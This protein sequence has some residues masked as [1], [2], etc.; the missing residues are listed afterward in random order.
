[1]ATVATINQCLTQLKSLMDTALV[2]TY[3]KKVYDYR[4][5]PNKLT[6]EVALSYQGQ[7]D[8]GSTLGGQYG[9]YD[10][11]AVIGA[12]V[13]ESNTDPE[14]ALRDAEQLLNTLE[15]QLVDLISKEGAAYRT[16]YWL[17]VDRKNLPPTTRPPSPFEI[18]NLR[19]ANVP[20]RLILG[21]MPDEE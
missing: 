21:A 7:H 17:K 4:T 9:A 5:L 12:Q 1:M 6:V 15:N 19:W 20:F 10:I 11:T 3:A 8:S 16:D 13:D 18:P 14:D 2:S